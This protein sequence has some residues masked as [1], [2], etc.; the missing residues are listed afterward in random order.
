MRSNRIAPRT[1]VVSNTRPAGFA[2]NHNAAFRRCE[3]EF[4]CVMN[5]DVRLP[6][7]PFPALLSCL[8]EPTV[9]LAAPAVL[10]PDGLIESTGRA[11]PTVPGLVRK[12]AGG[13]DGRMHFELGATVRQDWVRNVSFALR[14]NLRDRRFDEGYHLYYEDVTCAPHAHAGRTSVVPRSTVGQ[15]RNG[16]HGSRGS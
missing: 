8:G 3:T 16:H 12:A 4:F 14:R 5:P 7:N 9:G 11:F 13:P 2:T 1:T 15:P 6:A 10:N